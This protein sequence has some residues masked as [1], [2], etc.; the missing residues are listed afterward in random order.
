M[1]I[2]S[3]FLTN[4]LNFPFLPFQIRP[5]RKCPQQFEPPHK[6][7]SRKD[8]R[9]ANVFFTKQMLRKESVWE[10][11]QSDDLQVNTGRCSP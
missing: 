11:G 3:D 5:H 10:R 9:G 8:N 7:E 2:M 1:G 6:A 4:S